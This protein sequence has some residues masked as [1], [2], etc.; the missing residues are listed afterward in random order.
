MTLELVHPKRII[1]ATSFLDNIMSYIKNGT[2]IFDR[3]FLNMSSKKKKNNVFGYSDVR[4]V[5]E[6]NFSLTANME[7]S[8]VF[9]KKDV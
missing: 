3:H 6:E 5:L 7:T 1:S 4:L 2:L 8:V 9:L